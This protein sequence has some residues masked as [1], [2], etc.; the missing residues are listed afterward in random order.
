MAFFLR[1]TSGDGENF[2]DTAVVRCNP[3]G[4]LPVV[5]AYWESFAHR[6]SLSLLGLLWA[7]WMGTLGLARTMAVTW[8]SSG[9][10]TS[11]VRMDGWLCHGLTHG[12]RR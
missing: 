8:A 1:Q 11:G 4:C 9:I 6:E 3:G 10:S 7:T 5:P 12:W 2:D